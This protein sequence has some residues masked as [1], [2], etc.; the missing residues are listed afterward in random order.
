MYHQCFYH[1]VG[2]AGKST[3]G[4]PTALNVINIDGYL[5]TR[6]NTTRPEHGPA[7]GYRIAWSPEAVYAQNQ[8][9]A[10]VTCCVF[11]AGVSVGHRGTPWDLS[12]SEFFA[13]WQSPGLLTVPGSDQARLSCSH[14]IDATTFRLAATEAFATSRFSALQGLCQA[15]L[16]PEYFSTL[17]FSSVLFVMTRQV[18][19]WECRQ[20]KCLSV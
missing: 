7:G 14:C 15:L 17:F 10:R 4:V 2:S 1:V 11:Q 5:I 19:S 12:T 13:V 3:G 9:T 18:G 8:G 20:K 6:W 16:Y